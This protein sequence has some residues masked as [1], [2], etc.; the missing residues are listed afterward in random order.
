MLQLVCRLC[1]A[2]F[3]ADPG[4]AEVRCPK[5]SGKVTQD[6]LKSAQA[7]APAPMP[8]RTLACTHC[9][10]LLRVSGASPT[11]P[12]CGQGIDEAE[13]ERLADLLGGLET[14]VRDRLL[15]GDGAPAIVADLTDS[16]IASE[17]AWTYLDRHLADLPFERHKSWKES[18]RVQP[19]GAC[20]SCGVHGGLAP[21]EATWN[22][23]KEELQRYRSGWGG[24]EGDF[25]KRGNFTRNALYY[26]CPKCVK[27]ARSPEFAS[28]YP[29]RFGFRMERFGKAKV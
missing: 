25:E 2:K 11:C 13:G 27:T 4:A 23:T 8:P 22:V 19:P 9:L 20:D 3:E 17:R 7:G 29:Y 24:F 5:C 18:G 16:G 26:L 21:H 10:R 1:R 28:G 14:R 6:Q 12:Y 15:A